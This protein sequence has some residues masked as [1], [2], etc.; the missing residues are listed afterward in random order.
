MDTASGRR[1][2][3]R[4]IENR[5]KGRDPITGAVIGA[6]IAVHQTLGPGLLEHAY[7]MCL[8]HE[9]ASR[10]IPFEREVRV[11]VRYAGFTVPLAYRADFVVEQSVIVEVKAVELLAAVHHAQ[12]LTYLR[13]GGWSRGLLVNFWATRLEDGIVRY[14]L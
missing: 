14:V 8:A 11:P 4:P 13:V 2:F 1:A 10:A 5:W 12:L 6:A 9:L 3:P 7:S